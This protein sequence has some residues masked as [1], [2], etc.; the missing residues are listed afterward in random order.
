MYHKAAG[1]TSDNLRTNVE[2]RIMCHDNLKR[3]LFV[4]ATVAVACGLA[5]VLAGCS[6][7][8]GADKPRAKNI[9]LMISDGCGY[10][11]VDAASF[12]QYGRTGEQPYEKFQTQLGMSTYMAGQTYE[13]DQA[14]RYFNY[15]ADTVGDKY[16]RYTDSAAAATAMSTGIKTYRG[17][18][19]MDLDVYPLRHVVDAAEETGKATGV[20]TSVQLSHSTPA[21][22]VAHN[23]L[24]SNYEQIANEMFYESPLEVIIGCGHPAYTSNNEPGYTRD[25]N[26]D[27]VN[28]TYE[29]KY[30]GGE[31][32]WIDLSDGNLTGAYGEWTVIEDKT[33]FQDLM[34]GP[35]PD[36]VIGLARTISTLQ[37]NRSG[38]GSQIEPYGVDL[39][40]DVPTLEEMTIAA[41]N[42][43]DEYPDGFFLMV[44]GGAVDWASHSDLIVRMIEEQ[45][46]FNN[47]VDAV[48]NWI[49]RN[50][51]W[52]DTLVIVTADHECGYLAGP[53][54][55]L[56]PDG[57]I[58]T[59]I[60]NN[61]AGE[62][63]GAV[64]YS[65][66]H[67][68]S[69]V[70]FYANGPGTSL[71]ET[72][73]QNHDPVRGYYIDNTDVGRVLFEVIGGP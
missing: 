67:T 46:D 57:P 6:S 7:T 66:N 45:I 53:G 9:V 11:H 31:Q 5:T 22:F 39:N 3:W 49:E 36:R 52:N 24:R 50:S 15:V 17:S 54:S 60:V 58:W 28:D 63:P 27:G 19:G 23:E 13:P 1:N 61:G 25:S 64:F 47:A 29:Y 35:T 21:A 37:A 33:A 2:R 73:A 43:L 18:I 55:G 65:G 69:L 70:P 72:R 44:E 68:N 34:A 4:S 48:V 56:G 40:P 16:T 30:V 12:Y 51:S 42:V 32:T 26:G 71:F 8:N 62:V 38:A 20:I 14:W 41:L 59:E 10:N